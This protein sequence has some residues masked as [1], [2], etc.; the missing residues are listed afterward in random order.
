MIL[1]ISNNY[2]YSFYIKDPKIWK[3][4]NLPPNI[5]PVKGLIMISRD[6]VWD[7]ADMLPDTN[8]SL[9][10]SC[11]HDYLYSCGYQRV[12][13]TLL[14]ELVKCKVLKFNYIKGYYFTTDESIIGSIKSFILKVAFKLFHFKNKKFNFMEELQ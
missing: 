1:N 4:I 2:Y 10:L 8:Y 12:A 6:F 9:I 14:I 5:M 11:L 7:G 13:D 3:R